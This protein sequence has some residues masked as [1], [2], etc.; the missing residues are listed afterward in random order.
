MPT[1]TVTSKGQITLPIELRKK[2]GLKTGTKVDFFENEQGQYVLYPKTGSITDMKGI[3]QRL[4]MKPLG[5]VPTEEQMNEAIAEHVGLS[6]F[7]TMSD[8]GKANFLRLRKVRE[9][10]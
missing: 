10:A 7:E 3:F 6:D 8:E 5:Y 1:A 2:L 9:T 4:G